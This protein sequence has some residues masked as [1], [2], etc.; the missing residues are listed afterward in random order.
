[1]EKKDVWLNRRELYLLGEEIKQLIENE[2]RD[3]PI[4]DY[5]IFDELNSR[6]AL[7]TT[8]VRHHRESLGFDNWW[9]RRR[10]YRKE[11]E[12]AKEE[13]EN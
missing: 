4:R 1:M 13:K 10:K 8:K 2:D 6:F 3:N 11:K 9:L 12:H 7:S 5:Q